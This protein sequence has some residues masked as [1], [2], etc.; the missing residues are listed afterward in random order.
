[1]NERLRR[2]KNTKTKSRCRYNYNGTTTTLKESGLTGLGRY[3]V[4]LFLLVCLFYFIPS[5]FY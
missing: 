5:F 2:N 1:M 3:S 4:A